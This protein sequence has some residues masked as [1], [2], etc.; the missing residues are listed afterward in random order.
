[1]EVVCVREGTKYSGSYVKALRKQVKE[2]SGKDLLCLG[3]DVP[4]RYGW[5]GWGAKIELFSPEFRKYRPCFYIDLDT[6]I[7]NDF[8]DLLI[9][10]DRLLLIRDFNQT[11]RGNTGLMS[12][13]KDVE[14]H[15]LK[16]YNGLRPDGD[17]VNELP[18]GYLNDRYPHRIVSHK[19]HGVKSTFYCFH[20]KPKQEDI[21]E[22]W[23]CDLWTRL[24]S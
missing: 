23:I 8:S 5:K 19:K 4:L 15:R 2:F 11:Y 1:M 17:L 12:I 22:G 6:L 24:T 9:V 7:L 14:W 18:H 20:G 21:K 10:P 16:D 13:P 3:D